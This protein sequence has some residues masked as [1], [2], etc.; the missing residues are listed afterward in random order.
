MALKL[1]EYAKATRRGLRGRNKY[2]AKRTLACL[3]CGSDLVVKGKCRLCKSTRIH[4]FDSKAEYHRYNELLVLARSGIAV[5]LTVQPRF[6]LTVNGKDVGSYVGD[7]G[8]FRDGAY[9]VEDVKGGYATDTPLSRF[10]RKIVEAQY[11]IAVTII[12]R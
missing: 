11:G 3:E 1:E 7:F 12:R 5:D 8:Y 9:V 4:R 2:G 10:K 6:K